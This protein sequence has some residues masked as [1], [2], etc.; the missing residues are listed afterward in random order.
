M[1]LKASSCSSVPRAEGASQKRL[2][3][4]GHAH[5]WNRALSRRQ[6]FQTT[7]GI[8]GLVLGASLLPPLA[9]VL[10]ASHGG[11]TVL[12][13]PIPGGFTAFGHLFHFF[14]PASGAEPSTITDFNGI[15]GVANVGGTGTGTD[16]G[17]SSSLIFDADCRF[18]SGA[19]VGVDGKVHHGAAAFV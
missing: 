15:V 1:L 5:F 6:F 18:M 3:Y 17:V 14:L 12:P 8:T 10:F 4:A 2:A 13:N 11:S 7:A 9:P 19:Y 16:S